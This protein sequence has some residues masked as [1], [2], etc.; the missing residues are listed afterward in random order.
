MSKAEISKHAKAL[1]AIGTSKGG[2]ARAEN[3]TEQERHDI[4]SLAAQ[5]RWGET[6]PR[7]SYQGQIEISD[8]VIAC[9]VL[10]NGTRLLTQQ[11]F[12]TAIGRYKKAKA[13]TGSARLSLEKG[14]PP[15][16]IAENLQPFIS[17]E[18]RA[19]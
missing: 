10:E 7:A 2:K 8:R 19:I 3:L 5:A 4:A 13:R 18:L 16:L 11:S 1:S 14:L 6:I 9:A 12:L 15:F 17:D